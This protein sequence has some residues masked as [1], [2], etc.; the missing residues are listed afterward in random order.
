M[1]TWLAGR[2]TLTPMS[3]S[4]PPLILRV[5]LP[6][7][8]SPSLCLEMTIS[9]SRIRCAFLR[10]RTISPVSSST[11]SRRTS[12]SSP[13]CGRRLVFPL[14]ERDEA[15][16]LV[17]DVDDDLVADD[18]DDLALDD[19]ADLEVLALRVE[20]PVEF[21]GLLAGATT[22]VS[23][24]SLTSNSRSRLRSTMCRPFR[25]NPSRHERGSPGETPRG[26][27]LLRVAGP[28][29][30]MRVENGPLA[31]LEGKNGC[32]GKKPTPSTQRGGLTQKA[33]IE[34]APAKA[35]VVR[36]D[37]EAVSFAPRLAASP[38]LD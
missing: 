12:T 28:A 29:G 23:S 35:I 25:S 3:T 32:Q 6:L 26:G 19:A 13:G 36:A 24:S 31:A 5:T 10:E 34:H 15:L 21:V 20:E 30:P 16:G 33:I 8:T 14:V 11:A 1:S 37:F 18:L 9:Q 38:L 27:A 2:K 7:T 17:A 22:A 4:R